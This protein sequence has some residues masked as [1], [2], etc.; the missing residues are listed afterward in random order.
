[1]IQYPTTLPGPLLENYE[2]NQKSN[3][4][5]TEMDSGQTRVRQLYFSVPTVITSKWLFS[6]EQAADFEAFIHS[7][8]GGAVN[9]FEM[10]IKTPVGIQTGLL[11]FITSPLDA[12][13]PASIKL[14]QY[15]ATIELKTRPSLANIEAGDPALDNL[16]EFISDVDMSLYYQ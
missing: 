16:A 8:L 6:A 12:C 11:R 5:N 14:W 3:R 9:W 1:M 2:L 7:D 13:S 10:L 4:S 15:T